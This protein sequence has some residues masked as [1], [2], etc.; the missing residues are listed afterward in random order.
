MDDANSSESE[1]LGEVVEEELECTS[2]LL[3]LVTM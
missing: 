2:L 3:V 1:Q